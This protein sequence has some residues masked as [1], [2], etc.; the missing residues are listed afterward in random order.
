MENLLDFDAAEIIKSRQF[1]TSSLE[2]ECDPI[3]NETSIAIRL[4]NLGETYAPCAA[5]LAEYKTAHTL[6][7]EKLGLRGL[8]HPLFDLI[9]NRYDEMRQPYDHALHELN[10]CLTVEI[11]YMIVEAVRLVG[12]TDLATALEVGR[13]VIRGGEMWD[14]YGFTKGQ[15]LE[16]S[17]TAESKTEVEQIPSG[18]LCPGCGHPTD[19]DSVRCGI[20]RRYL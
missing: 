15:A 13:C 11:L 10:E 3:V 4:D 6:T 9:E 19:P 7:T 17:E 14:G 20:C 5:A 18:N 12:V 1:K 16:S 8:N 2:M